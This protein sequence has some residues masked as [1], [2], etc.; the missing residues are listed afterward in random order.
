[1][2]IKQI[3]FQNMTFSH[4]G[5]AGI[6]LTINLHIERGNVMSNWILVIDDDA[7]NL[8]MA[9]RI[10]SA[11][12]MRVSCL[13]SGE[14][15]IKF[16][17]DNRPDLILLD[18]H[19]PGMDGFETIAAI[20]ENKATADIPV[21]F[22]TADDDSNAET[23]GLKAGAMDFIKKPFVPEVL[24]LRVR[25]TIDLIRLQTNLSCEVEKKTQEVMALHAKQEKV[26]MQIVTALS[27]AIDAKDTYTNGHSTRVAEYSREIARH[28]GLSEEKQNEIYMMGLLHDVGKIGIPD[29]IIN[30]PA[31]LS[32]E[33]YAIIKTHPVMGAGILK[34]ITEF[35]KLATGARWHHERYDGKGYPDGISGEEIPLE[36]RIIAVA[37]AYDAMSSKRSY[38]GVLPQDII[39]AEMEKGKGTQ[40]DPVFAEIML[41]MIDED[42]DYQ[43]R[44]K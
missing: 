21:I 29:A 22:L 19:M 30:K 6:V 28:A 23:R 41:G 40:F 14:D 13:K 17:Q 35:P 4:C 1:M 2:D 44:E 37:D 34:N 25:H 42:T 43:M 5:N 15:A 18:I 36:A 32:D 12:K 31:K 20:R 24:L 8:R 33:E 26:S 39:R 7:S 11:E 27:G 3:G 10:L 9:S 38:R 16:L